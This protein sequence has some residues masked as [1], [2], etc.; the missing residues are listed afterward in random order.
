MSKEEIVRIL[1]EWDR[2]DEIVHDVYSV[3]ADSPD[4]PGAD[5]GVDYWKI[6]GDEVLVNWSCSW[7]YGGYDSGRF[8]F[9][10]SD[11]YTPG[12]AEENVDSM[13][14]AREEREAALKKQKEDDQYQAYLKLKGIYDG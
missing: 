12:A 11:L 1:K 4:Y 6:I 14:V 7:N 13:R 5:H 8:R 2:L 9:P 10:L 3:Y